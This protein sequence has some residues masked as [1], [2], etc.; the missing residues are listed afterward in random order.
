M[1][2]KKGSEKTL[3]VYWFLIL[4]IVAGGIFYLV[5]I[6]YGAPYNFRYLERD[7]LMDKVAD[8]LVPKGYILPDVVLAEDKGLNNE[9]FLEK[10]H[11]KFSFEYQKEINEPVQ[12]FVG[13]EVFSADSLKEYYQTFVPS[14]NS[15]EDVD[16][17][18]EKIQTILEEEPIKEIFV[19]NLNLRSVSELERN[20]QR[21]SRILYAVSEEGHFYLIKISAIVGNF[22]KNE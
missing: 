9:N 12:Y 17:A 11:L 10:C 3:S 21:N 1:R 20:S 18:Q 7:V 8:C 15:D 16:L 5:A 13:V 22:K 2:N 19:G 4:G 14:K 6:F